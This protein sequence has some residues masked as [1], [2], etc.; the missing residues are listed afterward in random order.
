[1]T[2]GKWGD[3]DDVWGGGWGLRWG[4]WVEAEDW[5]V[6]GGWGL[7][8]QETVCHQEDVL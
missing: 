8:S 2:E 1:M 3:S 7:G 5:G 4:I 6:G